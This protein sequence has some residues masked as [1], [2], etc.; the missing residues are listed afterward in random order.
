MFHTEKRKEKDDIKY[1]FVWFGG[2]I[3]K[4]T[5]KTLLNEIWIGSFKLRANLS[6]FMRQSVKQTLRVEKAV[7]RHQINFPAWRK[8]E[9]SY[10]E[11]FTG[12]ATTAKPKHGMTDEVKYRKCNGFTYTLDMEEL[13]FLKKCLLG[14]LKEIAVWEEV[15]S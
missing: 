9:V 8:E 13:D 6:K 15:G 10:K 5:M 1:G 4:N 7:P 2:N 14:Y 12:R 11:A 3:N